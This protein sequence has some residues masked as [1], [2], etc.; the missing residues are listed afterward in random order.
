M[1]SEFLET[2][3]VLDYFR[4]IDTY[5]PF[6]TGSRVFLQRQENQREKEGSESKMKLVR[7]DILFELLKT[8]AVADGV[9]F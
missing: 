5:Q 2:S 1:D 3:Q 4:N 6:H 8:P 7:L 9:S